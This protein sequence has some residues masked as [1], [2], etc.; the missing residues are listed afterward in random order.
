MDIY[1]Q[2]MHLLNLPLAAILS[3]LQLIC[4]LIIT[5]GHNRFNRK[6]VLSSSTRAQTMPVRKPKRG[7]EKFVVVVL[8]ITLLPSWS[9]RWQPGVTVRSEAGRQPR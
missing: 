2:A 1:I 4:T 3:I 8:V 9:H 5:I 7:F 6:D